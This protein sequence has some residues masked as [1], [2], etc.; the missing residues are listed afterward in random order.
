MGR[1]LSGEGHGVEACDAEDGLANAAMSF[2]WHAVS[3][4]LLHPT[5]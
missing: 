3:G 2:A 4:V 5:R 1:E